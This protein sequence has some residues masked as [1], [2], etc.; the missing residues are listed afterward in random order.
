MALLAAFQTLLHRY[1]AQ[2]DIVVGSPEAGRAHPQTEGL[3]GCFINVLLLRTDFSGTP[4]FRELLARVRQVVLDARSHQELPLSKLVQELDPGRDL[5]QAPLF[6]VIFAFEKALSAPQLPGLEVSVRELD[7]RTA[8][9][10]VSLFAAEVAQGLRLKFECKKDL[11]ERATIQRM[12]THMS[13]LLEEI[14]V[15]PDRQVGR[16]PIL[17]ATER[18]Q[19]TSAWNDSRHYPAHKCIHELFEDQVERT[20][21]KIALVFEEQEMSYAE[22]NRRSNQLA[23]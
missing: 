5:S 12:L 3:V 21:E 17:D 4:T 13:K 16:L 10:D 11:F 15:D 22:L 19:L 18:E 9:H 2:E 8:L 14:A 1:S 20:P 6:Q 23:R 7:T